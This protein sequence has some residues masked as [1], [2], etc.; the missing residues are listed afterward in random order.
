[1]RTLLRCAV[2][3]TLVVLSA[4][5]SGGSGDSANP[6]P[7]TMSDAEILTIGKQV[8]RCFRDNGVPTFPDPR[9]ED[10]RLV[11]PEAME[12]QIEGQYSQQ[13]LEQAQH[14][15]QNIMDQLP[16]SAI[17][18]EEE[19]REPDENLPGPGDVDALRKFAHCMRENGL[20]EWPDPKADGSFPLMGTPLEQE[21]KSQRVR[22]AAEKCQQHWHGSITYS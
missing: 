22:D 16:A 17:R 19:A 5:S 4:C 7:T 3:L 6:S 14:A 15:C 9:V 21:G 18:G 13:V 20:P 2:A 12:A 10:G 1:M 8:A 11:L